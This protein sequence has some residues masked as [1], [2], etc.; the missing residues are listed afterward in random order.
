MMTMPAGKPPHPATPHEPGQSADARRRPD[1][2]GY[3]TNDS[4]TPLERPAEFASK[5]HFTPPEGRP[6]CRSRLDRL[7]NSRARHPL[8]RRDSGRRNPTR[9]KRSLRTSLITDPANGLLPP[10][11]E[12]ASDAAPTR[13]AAAAGPFGQR[14]GIARRERCITWCNVGPPMLPPTYYANFHILRQP[15]TCDPSRADATR[16]A[17]FRSTAPIPA[18]REVLYG[19]ARGRWEGDTLVV[20]TRLHRQDA[21]PR[22][23]LEH[24]PGHSLERAM[25]VVERFTR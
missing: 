4:Y 7:E 10:L 13:G 17:S 22:T 3:W 24:T 1:L 18:R 12:E 19:D 11:T 9:R 8:R 6:L 25:H 23:S 5:S 16:R 21:V 20:D 15:T 14:A 2:Q